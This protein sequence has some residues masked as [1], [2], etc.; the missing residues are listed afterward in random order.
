ML[1]NLG[2]WFVQEV[3]HVMEE[4]EK[5]LR[6]SKEEVVVVETEKVRATVE[7]A[8]SQK[9][10]TVQKERG[11][12]LHLDLE[13]ADTSG[14]V[15]TVNKKQHQNVQRQQQQTNS[16]KNGSF[17]FEVKK[18]FFVL[19]SLHFFAGLGGLLDFSL[20]LPVQSNSVPLPMS[21]P[22]WPGGLPPMG[23]GQIRS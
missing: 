1:R 3:K 7:E 11:I 23:Y 13:K 12:D 4:E 16:E 22:S 17:N 15:I 10:A 14:I 8:E 20:L 6:I 19:A 5:P 9:P 21:V 2:V 18:Y